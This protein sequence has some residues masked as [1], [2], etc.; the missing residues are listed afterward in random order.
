MLDSLFSKLLKLALVNKS[1]IKKL[2]DDR[3]GFYDKI[4]LCNEKLIISETTLKVL[5]SFNDLRNKIA[6]RY[7]DYKYLTKNIH[8]SSFEKESKKLKDLDFE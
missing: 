1:L 2:E 4:I 6:H 5:K 3:I 7:D 8:F